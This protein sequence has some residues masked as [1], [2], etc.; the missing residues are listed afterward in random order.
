MEVLEFHFNPPSSNEEKLKIERVFDSFCF[1]PENTY[2]KRMGN[3]YLIGELKHPIERNLRFLERIAEVAK[4]KYYSDFLKT[5]EQ[6]LKDTLKSLNNFFEKELRRENTNWMGNLSLALLSLVQR[7]NSEWEINFT[8]IGR[9]KLLLLRA[10]KITDIGEK[11]N[12]Q[13]IEPYPLKVFS[14]LVNGSLIEGDIILVL[15]EE[16]FES[17]QKEN[18]L[19]QLEKAEKFTGEKFKKIL[20]QKDK[21]LK[22]IFGICVF[23][24]LLSKVQRKSI[25]DIKEKFSLLKSFKYQ[26]LIPKIGVLKNILLSL[27]QKINFKKLSEEMT[28]LKKGIILIGIFILLLLG[29]GFL[30]HLGEKK[31]IDLEKENLI[32]IEE[33]VERA[34]NLFRLNQKEKA[35]LILQSA[36]N[37]ISSLIKKDTPLKEEALDL[38]DNIEKTLSEFTNSKLIENPQLLFEFKEEDSFSK[39]LLFNSSLYL[40]SP[41]L[42][43]LLMFNLENKKLETIKE[44]D[45]PYLVLILKNSKFPKGAIFNGNIYF[46]N[47]LEGEIIKYS[48]QKNKK[49]KWMRKNQELV[50]AKS[51]AVD[52]AI[53]ILTKENK[54]QKYYLGHL[55]KSFKI[56]IFPELKNPIQ[57]YTR[58]NLKNLYLLEPEKKRVIVLDKKGN[59]I[60]QIQSEKFQNL[61]DL[62]VSE[63]ETTL[64]LLD[65]K[66]VYQISL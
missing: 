11:L 16:V 60:S 10:G 46:L 2:E 13:E 44:T 47:A 7:E 28:P 45:L 29:G 31:K 1:E 18:I 50:S 32:A 52:G 30:V 59:V 56:N 33:E 3:L 15:T 43:Q 17:F 22:K 36:H 12:T 23:I 58:A 51:I 25:L 42:P 5:P 20:K 26:A 54:I 65:A 55:K 63:D 14:N 66:K 41:S 4:Q 34:K 62:T 39:I 9:T 61:L 49:E 40:Y 37:E 21:E 8:K 64:W 57:L 27:S 19:Q 48:P 24:Y 38:K 6:A 35:F 53:W